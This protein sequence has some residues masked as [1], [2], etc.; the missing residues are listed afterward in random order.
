[1]APIIP[2]LERSCPENVYPD[3]LEKR[4]QANG[5]QASDAQV[6][7]AGSSVKLG[8]RCLDTGPKSVFFYKVR[9]LLDGSTMGQTQSLFIIAQVVTSTACL[10][11]ALTNKRASNTRL[12]G[13]H[14]TES[15][16]LLFGL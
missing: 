11:R 12:G 2:L 9:S 13:K 14:S 10:C 16:L 4:T 8:H 3:C 15:V 6:L 1:M 7:D 5:L